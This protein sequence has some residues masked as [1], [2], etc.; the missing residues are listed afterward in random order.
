MKT[1]TNPSAPA[2]AYMAG[3][4]IID[5]EAEVVT[6]LPPPRGR[7]PMSTAELQQVKSQ[8]DEGEEVY[9]SMRPYDGRTSLRLAT[10]EEMASTYVV[11]RLKH[12][13]QVR[14][15]PYSR[16]SK[17]TPAAPARLVEVPNAVGP[18]A[19]KP[20]PEPVQE[21]PR[22]E[23]RSIPNAFAHLP[24]ILLKQ[25]QQRANEPAPQQPAKP[26]EP[27]S[28][29]PEIAITPPPLDE[30]ISTWLGMGDMVLEDYRSKQARK[31]AQA[32]ENEAAAEALVHEADKLRA[33]ADAI[34]EQIQ[35][36]E[37]F[38]A[39]AQKMAGTEPGK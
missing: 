25:E 10:V 23:L 13:K 17:A 5:V 24:E 30:S 18:V 31:R 33:E 1:A 19:A 9:V 11:V 2:R 15:L 35:N 38:R 36:F 6:P 7:N 34:D 12:N 21:R 4:S 39:L 32:D 3:Q 14:K 22:P 27:P 20:A 37:N 8:F 28:P 16:L 29:K 26:I